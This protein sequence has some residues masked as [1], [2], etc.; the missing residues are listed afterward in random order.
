M[1]M[2]ADYYLDCRGQIVIPRRIIE[3]NLRVSDDVAKR[4]TD[5]WSP[6]TWEI[7]PGLRY[8]EIPTGRYMDQPG[9]NVGHSQRAF[10]MYW[11]IKAGVESGG[12]CLGVGTAGVNGPATFGTDLYTN[13][14]PVYKTGQGVPNMLWNVSDAMP[15]CAG[16]FDAV[17]S[18]HSFEH[19]PQQ[20]A[21]IN[22]L[23]GLLRQ[24]GVL[25]IVMPDM[26]FLPRGQLD[27]SHTHEFTATEFLEWLPENLTSCPWAY[28]E[29]NTLDNHFS[30]NTVLQ[31]TG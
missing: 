29:H 1:D 3:P 2:L 23:F 5:R 15:F 28:V 12:V 10:D 22:K 11:G 4:I 14:N 26:A 16:T 17:I 8:W 13:W 7:V 24:G 9:Q 18:N 31:R 19:F 27:A 25:C 6:N 21:V 20:G 30:F